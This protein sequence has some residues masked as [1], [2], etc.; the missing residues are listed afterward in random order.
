LTIIADLLTSRVKDILE[1][2]EKD[3]S[4]GKETGQSPALD[5]R[6]TL[7][8][9]R[10]L[11]ITD[12]LRNVAGLPDPVGELF[13][14]KTLPNGLRVRKQ[15]V[16]L[17]VLGAIYEARPNVMID[18]AGL[19]I[20]AGN[21]VLLLGGSE[22]LNSNRVLVDVIQEALTESGLPAEVVQFID[23]PLR[24]RVAEM[25]GMH[26]YV[27]MLI[28]HGGAALH[29]YCRENSSIPVITRGIGVC[30]LFVDRI[31]DLQAAL[32]VIRN[33]KIQCPTVCNSLDTALVHQ[34]I[35]SEFLP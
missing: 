18:I 20:K 27:D 13:D 6:L 31:A 7:T 15:R 10:I 12:D 5:D 16:P 24:E 21:V 32:R 33:A 8:S 3:V 26:Q 22:T 9:S 23:A 19:A 29:Q 4:A 35:A 30:H 14:D 25:L 11:G 34:D 28:P 2:N 17:G 1:A